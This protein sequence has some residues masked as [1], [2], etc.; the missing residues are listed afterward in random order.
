LAP[1][2]E[3][4]LWK[5]KILTAKYNFSAWRNQQFHQII[6]SVEIHQQTSGKGVVESRK[7]TSI[8]ALNHPHVWLKQKSRQ[9]LIA[10]TAPIRSAI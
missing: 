6:S 3:P 1:A 8:E 5:D 7:V 9:L 4:I 2:T 10:R